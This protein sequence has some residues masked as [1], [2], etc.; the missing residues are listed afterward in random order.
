MSQHAIKRHQGKSKCADAYWYKHEAAR[1]AL[2]PGMA[3]VY[4]FVAP[5]A[6]KVLRDAGIRVDD[7]DAPIRRVVTLR[8][9]KPSLDLI[10][11]VWLMAMLHTLVRFGKLRGPDGA[12]RAAVVQQLAALV[13]QMTPEDHSALSAEVTLGADRDAWGNFEHDPRFLRE[14]L[15]REFDRLV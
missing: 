10:A 13:S 8:H 1:L 12:Q 11:P 6:W 4:D 5:A 15:K 3:V 9:D 2:P 7:P 14:L